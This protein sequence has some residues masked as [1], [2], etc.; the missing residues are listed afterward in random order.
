VLGFEFPQTGQMIP[1]FKIQTRSNFDQSK[2][3]IP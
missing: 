3:D 1:K 2:N